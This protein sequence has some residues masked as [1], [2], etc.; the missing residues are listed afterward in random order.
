MS[1][2]ELFQ[3]SV[4]KQDFD[5]AFILQKLSHVPHVGAVC[6]FVGVVRDVAHLELEHY[7][8]MTEKS[9]YMLLEETK[10][11]FDAQALHVIHRIGKLAENQQIVL[12]AAATPHRGDAFLACEFL[13]DHIK[14]Q[15]PFWK[16]EYPLPTHSFP[17]LPIWV[18]AKESD[19]AVLAKWYT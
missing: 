19:D 4:Q 3:A 8:G 12:V 6:S 16:K 11:R 14:T 5:A 7:P 9:L 17:C 10:N 1:P 15:V 18:S 2:S 13:I